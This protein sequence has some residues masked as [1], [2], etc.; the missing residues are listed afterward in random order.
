MVKGLAEL[1]G[2]IVEASS[3]GAGR[4][5]EFLVRLPL[6]REPAALSEMPAAPPSAGSHLR[7]LVVEDNR[8]GA[9][10]LRLLLELLGHEVRVAYSGPEGVATAREFRPDVVL[11]DIGLPGLDGYGV[12]RELRLNP[13]TARVRL[14]A[15]TGYG[16]DEDLRRSR[17]AGFDHHLIK[18][19]DPAVLSKLLSSG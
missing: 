18:P 15:L 2:G 17:E 5:A 4:G 8:D 14:L 11:C 16:Q 13:T 10:S 3:E 12:A 7:I 19:A 6:E 9:D 1:H